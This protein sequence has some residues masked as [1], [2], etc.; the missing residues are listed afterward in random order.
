[1]LMNDKIMFDLYYCISSAKHYRNEENIG[2][3][4]F[5]TSRVATF[6]EKSLE[7]EIFSR[8]GKSQGISFLVRE[9]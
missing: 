4:Y 9:I 8:S 1:M 2:T 7:N 3:L 6:R 5:I